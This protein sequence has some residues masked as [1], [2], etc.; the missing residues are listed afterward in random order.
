MFDLKLIDQIVYMWLLTS[1]SQDPHKEIEKLADHMGVVS[2][3]ALIDE[4]V[5]AVQIGKMKKGLN[6]PE[7]NSEDLK[8]LLGWLTGWL[9]IVW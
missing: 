4:I 6:Y 9:L 2:S 1:L 8:K 5:D 3:P 7:E